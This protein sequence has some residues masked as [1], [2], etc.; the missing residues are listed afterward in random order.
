[1]KQLLIAVL[2]SVI[3]AQPIVTSFLYWKLDRQSHADAV[4]EIKNV[5]VLRMPAALYGIAQDHEFET[6]DETY[7][8]D[9]ILYRLVH[10]RIVNNEL[11]LH[12]LRDTKADCYKKLYLSLMGSLSPQTS[13]DQ[14][15]E[16][17]SLLDLTAKYV[18]NIED[19]PRFTALDASYVPRVSIPTDTDNW[20]SRDLNP[21]APPP[22]WS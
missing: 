22:K 20:S 7:L 21:V 15:S 18:K 1:M 16:Q 6:K 4:T 10:K 2:A 12:L 13:G 11:Q 9:E 14:G 5:F 8:V 17:P 3:F 19:Y